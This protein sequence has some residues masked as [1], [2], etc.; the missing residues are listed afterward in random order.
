VKRYDKLILIALIVVFGVGIFFTARSAFDSYVTFAEAAESDR[1]VQ[2]KGTPIDGTL[3]EMDDDVYSFELQDMAGETYRVSA[4]GMIPVNLFDADYVVV[5]GR[6]T[7]DEF[8][9]N[10]ILVKCPSKYEAQ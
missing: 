9:G 8:A 5:K 7:G 3:Q 10:Q 6:F 2:V 4:S 1:N